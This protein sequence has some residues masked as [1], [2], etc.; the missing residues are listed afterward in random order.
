M[1]PQTLAHHALALA[2]L[3]ALIFGAVAAR[4]DFCTLGA[5][6]DGLML[7]RWGRMRAWLLAIA[8]AVIGANLLDLTGCVDLSRTFYEAA[9]I[10][11]LSN[12]LG[13]L[14]FGVGMTYAT[15]CA[16]RN[17]VRIGGGSLRSLVI[18]LVMGVSAYMTLKGLFGQW[19]VEWLDPVALNTHGFGRSGQDLGALF[20]G[21]FGLGRHTIQALF[22]VAVSGALLWWVFRDRGFVHDGRN[23][24]AGV[25]VGALVTAGWYLTGH[26]ARYD[27]GLQVH[28]LLAYG[29][30]TG[31]PESWT[32]VGPVAYTLELLM[33]YTDASLRLTFGIVGV[34]GVVL[35]SF[36]WSLYSGTFRWEGFRGLRDL[37]R[38]LAGGVLMGVGGVTG[39]GCTIGQGITGVSTLAV[40]SALAFAGILLGAALTYRL[41]YWW[42][43]YCMNHDAPWTALRA[44]L[45][46]PH[47][48]GG[49]LPSSR[50]PVS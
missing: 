26:F 15:G 29:G 34:V 28:Y 40:G 32:F 31:A 36:A 6:Y 3:L 20:A 30:G 50:E 25:V 46:P 5:V 16:H 47:P 23:L 13:G 27:D 48:A 17:L 41:P 22:T 8:V 37:R 18:V 42:A 38:A 21:A 12:L 24:F 43:V 7:G 9:Q 1:D 4:T 49:R 2:F 33:L 11:W 10:H 45:R 19:R 39:M 14:L 35:G 44:R